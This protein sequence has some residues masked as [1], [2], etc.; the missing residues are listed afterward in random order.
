MKESLGNAIM[1]G[2]Y[3]T[4]VN[5]GFDPFI[6]GIAGGLASWLCVFPLDTIK[7]RI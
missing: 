7:T 1:F 6:C 3:F 4:G 5:Q 2:T